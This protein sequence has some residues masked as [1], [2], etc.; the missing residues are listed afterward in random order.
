MRVVGF[1]TYDSAR[2]PRVAVL[3]DGLRWHGHD[4]RE[5]NRPWTA[6][7]ASRVR[8]LH[9]PRSIG[10]VIFPLLTAWSL[11]LFDGFRERRSHPDMVVVGYLGHFDVL[12]A[13]LIFGKRRIVLDHLVSARTT[14][15]DRRVDSRVTLAVLG[16]VD[17][18][19]LACAGTIVVDTPERLAEIPVRRRDD[20]VVLPVGATSQW[21]A[22]AHMWP[23]S[24]SPL[25]V[26]FVGVYTPLH[27]T[28]TIGEAIGALRHRGDIVFTMI[29]TGQDRP[30]TELAAGS[31]DYVTW[32]DWVDPAELPSVLGGHHV[33]LGIFG[34]T[35][36]AQNVVPTKVYQA[37]AASRVVVTSET[38][39]QRRLL[40][41]AGVFVSPG[42]SAHLVKALTSLAEHPSELMA[43]RAQMQRSECDVRP[44]ALVRPL[45]SRSTIGKR[46]MHP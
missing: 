37:I 13:R 24:P 30:A 2:H 23:A 12:L 28:I 29:G 18:A 43:M 32:I 6:D 17:Q 14:A 16:V 3:L 31:S 11:L 21:R 8:L 39:P 45:F 5:I 41:D 26:V 33:A 46:V 42:D 15:I 44:E 9:S 19:A 20:V 22:V 25:R 1:G 38:S 34:T 40:G 7:T 27:G 10:K 35:S 4:V 36:K